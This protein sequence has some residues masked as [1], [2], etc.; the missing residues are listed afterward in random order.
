MS[1]KC[2]SHKKFFDRW[3]PWW[4]WAWDWRKNY[5]SQGDFGDL[6]DDLR[7]VGTHLHIVQCLFTVSKDKDWY[8]YD[9]FYTYIIQ[10]SKIYKVIINGDSCVNI[11]SKSAIER[12]SLKTEPHL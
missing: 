10:N 8:R 12:M 6:E 9:V 3:D 5:E 1:I 7:A 11:I 2:I 4:R